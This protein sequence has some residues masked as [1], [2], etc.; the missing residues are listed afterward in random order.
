[1]GERELRLTSLSLRLH[2]GPPRSREIHFLLGNFVVA[3]SRVVFPKFLT[4]VL[5]NDLEIT[6][7]FVLLQELLISIQRLDPGLL[8]DPPPAVDLVESLV[9]LPHLDHA[10]AFNSIGLS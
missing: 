10:L 2:L 3:H 6:F 7:L 4:Q 8:P 5:V 1:M 9:N